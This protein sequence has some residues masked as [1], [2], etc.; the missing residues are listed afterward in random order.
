MP[1]DFRFIKLSVHA[2][3][4]LAA[5]TAAKAADI[6]TAGATRCAMS[7]WSQD[8]DPAGLNVRAAPR[9]DAAIVATLPPERRQGHDSYAVEFR[10]V[11]SRDGWLLIEKAK[12][13]DYENGKGDRT[14]FA[15]RGWVS[16]AKVGFEINDAELRAAPRDDAP[17]VARLYDNSD[18]AGSFGPDSA[19]VD[20]VF[21]CDGDYADVLLHMPKG[22]P[23]RGWATRICSNQVTT[24]V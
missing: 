13:V 1:R 18:P 21:G 15:G 7:G 14:I 22:K 19:V 10:I 4:A 6:D 2:A 8:K 20:R 3:L 9:A 17:V 5:M 11:G 23:M 24:C 12:I 16:G